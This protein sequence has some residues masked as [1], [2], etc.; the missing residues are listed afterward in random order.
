MMP[1]E[2]EFSVHMSQ[3]GINRNDVIVVYDTIGMFSAPRAWYMF[4]A[5]GANN[6]AVL[7]G[8]FPMWKELG[9]PVE[10]GQMTGTY[11]TERSS[12]EARYNPS[13]MASLDEVRMASQ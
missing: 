4:K 9:F 13:S 10:D 1:S 12:F 8:G 7:D 2:Q 6:V 3:L 5:C 11:R